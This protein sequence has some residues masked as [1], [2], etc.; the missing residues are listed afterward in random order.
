ML[1]AGKNFLQSGAMGPSVVTADEVAEA[2]VIA[3]TEAVPRSRHVVG[4]MAEHLIALRG[5]MT[6]AQWDEM[7]T[8]MYPQPQP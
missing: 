2:I 5:Q 4:A 1:T 7:M 6:D 8:T 3:A